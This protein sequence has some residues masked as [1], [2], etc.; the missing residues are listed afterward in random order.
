ME[1]I[2]VLDKLPPGISDA[3]APAWV[4]LMSGIGMIVGFLE[5][6]KVEDPWRV[7]VLKLAAKSS[8]STLAGILAFRF[9]VAMDV[10]PK[11]HVIVVA[12][13]AHMGTEFLKAAGEWL[14]GKLPQ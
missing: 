9:L 4:W 10:D 2:S 3:L 5:D 11:W 7:W 6:F 12:I 13:A 14:K 1:S 8:S